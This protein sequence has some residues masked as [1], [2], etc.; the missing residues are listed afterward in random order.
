MSVRYPSPN[1][2]HQVC[3]ELGNGEN[4][5]KKEVRE[6]FGMFEEVMRNEKLDEVCMCMYVCCSLC[7]HVML[8]QFLFVSFCG[9]QKHEFGSCRTRRRIIE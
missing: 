6:M 2:W 1:G 3:R 9:P 8:N 7:V 5:E 4:E